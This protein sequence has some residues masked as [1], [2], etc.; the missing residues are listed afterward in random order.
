MTASEFESL[1]ARH[2]AYFQTGHTRPA[3]WREAQLRA[4]QA[5]MTERSADFFAALWKDL[6]RNRVDADATDVGFI[7]READYARRQVRQWMRPKHERTPLIFAPGRTIVRFDPLGVGLIIG[8]WNYPIMLCLSPLVA[9]IA[10]GNAAVIKPSEVSPTCAETIARLLPKYLDPEAF[11]VVLGGVTETT[12]LLE[13]RWDH[14]FFTGGP[15]V[16]KIVMTAAARNLTPLVLELGGKNPT[17]VHSSADLRVAARRIVQ[18]RFVNSGQTCTAPDYVLVFRDVAAAFVSELKAAITTFY[19]AD[20]QKSPDYGRIVSE[21]HFDRVVKLLGSGDVQ[22]G[23]QQ[24]RA[25]LY[26]APTILTNVALTSPAMQEEIFGPVLPVL[27]VE[28]I[29]TVLDIVNAQPT[30]LALYVFATDRSLA[31][32]LLN[33]TSSGDAV[34]NDCTVQP[35]VRELPFGGV[36]HSGMGKY[37]GEW[38]FRAYTNARGVLYRSTK[39]DPLVRYPPFKKYARLRDFLIRKGG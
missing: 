12:A 24:D 7:A 14:I 21:R 10:A 15:P 9:A 19:G 29:E 22:H 33:E 11:S 32:L 18:G 8:A 28:R 31:E 4:L 16:G 17:V 2:R 38:G 20:P 25:D 34:I 30:P 37:H 23:G 26:I 6:R 1:L 39:V 3:A 27:E 35:L 13:Q 5:L 36:G